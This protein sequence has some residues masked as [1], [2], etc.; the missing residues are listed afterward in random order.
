M[1]AI[2]QTFDATLEKVWNALADEN[3]LKKWYFQ[4]ENYDFEVDKSFGK[5]LQKK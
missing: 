3:E 4:V 5:V 2:T 1:I